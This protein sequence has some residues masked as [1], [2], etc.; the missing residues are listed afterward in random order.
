M[1]V[2]DPDVAVL[3]N[4]HTR[5][6]VEVFLVRTRNAGL[7]ER[8]HELPVGAELIDL[9]AEMLLESGCSARIAVWRAIGHPDEPFAID[10]EAVREV[11]DPFAEAPH[12]LAVEVD[13]NHR[14]EIRLG[15]AVRATTIEDPQ[16][17]AVGIHLDAAR[18]SDLPT[19]E[20]VPVVID[21]VRSHADLSVHARDED[22]NEQCR[23]ACSSRHQILRSGQSRTLRKLRRE[24]FHGCRN[25]AL[26]ERHTGHR[27]R[28]LHAGKCTGE[29]Q[30]VEIADV[31]D[32]ERL[33]FQ[34]AEAGTER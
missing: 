10:E 31:A 29:H 17:L 34:A 6:T 30:V 16:M 24:K 26:P 32:A 14:I 8:H 19:F 20:L 18:D 9:M 4:H 23:N 5:R 1:A 27:Q 33:A 25:A 28:H 3:R 2:G 22:S 7:A 21:F 11:R 12:E 13:L 15:A